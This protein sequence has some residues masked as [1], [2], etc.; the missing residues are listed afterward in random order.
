MLLGGEHRQ[1]AAFI[2]ELAITCHALDLS[3][4]SLFYAG[5]YAPGTAKTQSAYYDLLS[6]NLLHLALAVRTNLY[7]GAL[8]DSD[9][10]FLSPC[11]FL[12]VRSKERDET[13]PFTIKDVC[14]KIIHA[15]S[16]GRLVNRPEEAR[17][18]LE[19]TGKQRSENWTLSISVE[20]FCEYVLRW[21]DDSGF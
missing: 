20:M 4:T 3:A 11:G 21:L 7:Q 17:T 6:R 15:D 14:D 2:R 13:R 16:V 9:E 18:V 12:D 5:T 1:P 19:L 10:S 8:Q